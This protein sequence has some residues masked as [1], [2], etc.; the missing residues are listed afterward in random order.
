MISLLP[1]GHAAGSRRQH[2]RHS[3]QDT[4]TT[5]QVRATNNFFNRL[6]VA[7]SKRCAGCGTRRREMGFIEPVAFDLAHVVH[8]VRV[9]T[10]VLI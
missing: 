2:G 8:R 1:W 4:E 3:Q 5:S 10:G 9:L 7:D 6:H